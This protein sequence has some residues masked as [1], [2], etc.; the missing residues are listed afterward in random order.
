M[1]CIN[2]TFTWKSKWLTGNNK[3]QTNYDDKFNHDWWI[4][5]ELIGHNFYIV[6]TFILSSLDGYK[7]RFT[8]KYGFQLIKNTDKIRNQQSQNYL[9]STEADTIKSLGPL[10][11]MVYS[12][13][14]LNPSPL[15]LCGQKM[16]VTPVPWNWSTISGIGIWTFLEETS[17]Y[18]WVVVNSLI[19]FQV[20]CH[21][22]L[23][24]I[25]CEP[26]V[27]PV[28][29]WKFWELRYKI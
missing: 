20:T 22:L 19:K 3:V 17:S 14:S 23:W 2:N 21:V 13:I 24:S 5:V 7:F 9:S 27:L 11:Q 4:L 25:S 29:F 15:D 18:S 16:N 1:Y 26:K 28:G 6:D 12:Q 10:L 8:L